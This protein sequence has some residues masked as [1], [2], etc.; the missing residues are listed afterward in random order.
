MTL[1]EA[2]VE[3]SPAAVQ[4]PELYLPAAVAY[5]VQHPKHLNDY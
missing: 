1:A 2:N 5:P 3:A 4:Y